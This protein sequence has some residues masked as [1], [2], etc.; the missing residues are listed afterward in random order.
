MS[1]FL[2]NE[3][4]LQ[5]DWQDPEYPIDVFP[6]DAFD[7][8]CSNEK[9]HQNMH[10]SKHD[11]RRADYIITVKGN[12]AEL[13]YPKDLND[14]DEVDTGKLTLIFKDDSRKAVEQIIWK[15]YTDGDTYKNQAI[16]SW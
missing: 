15:D 9:G 7:K 2:R 13:E 12:R 11:I 10:Y 4:G 16:T 3:N 14:K 6:V 5:I 8:E 1:R